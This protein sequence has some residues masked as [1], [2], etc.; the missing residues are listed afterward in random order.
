MFLSFFIKCFKVTTAIS[1]NRTKELLLGVA[2]ITTCLASSGGM[3]F[4]FFS[5]TEITYRTVTLAIFLCA[6]FA[7]SLQVMSKMHEKKLL[8][9]IGGILSEHQKFPDW[10]TKNITRKAETEAE[11]K[12]G[13]RIF[14][15]MFS[16]G[17]Y[18]PSPHLNFIIKPGIAYE[19]PDLQVIPYFHPWWKPHTATQFISKN[20]FEMLICCTTILSYYNFITIV[21]YAISNAQTHI[22]EINHSFRTAI[23]KNMKKYMTYA[24]FRIMPSYKCD[25]FIPKHQS[26]RWQH[27]FEHSTHEELVKLIKYQQFLHR[28]NTYSSVQ[29][30]MS[31]T[32][33]S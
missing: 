33:T 15:L 2:M 11:H 12:F 27:D 7:N 30:V 17:I 26:R 25:S 4:A 32:S 13:T 23:E 18:I 28:Y 8:R 5:T 20:F 22:Q 31:Y 1:N 9:I 10:V 14:I 6:G 16:L 19:D 24:D 21:V 29:L 3:I